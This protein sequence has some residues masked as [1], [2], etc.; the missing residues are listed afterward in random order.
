MFFVFR[1]LSLGAEQLLKPWIMIKLMTSFV[2][3]T[4]NS[5][6]NSLLMLVDFLPVE[7]DAT[8]LYFMQWT[9]IIPFFVIDLTY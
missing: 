6:A 1:C 7:T 5:N 8:L 3:W 9:C 4:F 2:F